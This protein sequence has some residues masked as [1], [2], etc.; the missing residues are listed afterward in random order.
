MTNIKV[1][2]RKSLLLTL[3][4]KTIYTFSLTAFK[5]FRHKGHDGLTNKDLLFQTSRN[6]GD[7]L[8]SKSNIKNYN[9]NKS[10]KSNE[11]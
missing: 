10:S 1:I 2:Y 7:Y 3:P 5:I 4:V 9:K 8:K 11:T 6:F